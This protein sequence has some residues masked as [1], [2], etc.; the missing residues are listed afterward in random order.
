MCRILGGNHKHLCTVDPV[1]FDNF[2][3][4]IP[5]LYAHCQRIA[6]S[7]PSIFN[8]FKTIF[9]SGSE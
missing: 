1:I 7:D 2:Y 4:F 5:L 6:F 3:H 8:V 9:S